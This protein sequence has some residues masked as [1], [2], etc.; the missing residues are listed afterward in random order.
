MNMTDTVETNVEVA[1]AAVEAAPVVA[2]KPEKVQLYKIFVNADGTEIER[3]HIGK[4]S[5][6]KNS[7]KDEAGNLVVTVVPTPDGTEEKATP[8]IITL[9]AAGNEIS[10]TEKGRGRPAKGMVQHTE[11]QYKGH[12]VKTQTPVTPEITPVATEAPTIV[13]APIDAVVESEIV[14]N[15]T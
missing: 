7:K 8:M 13:A 15:P 2:A 5:P 4:G 6:P 10:R 12:W 11:G 14:T 3:K 1:V 9:D